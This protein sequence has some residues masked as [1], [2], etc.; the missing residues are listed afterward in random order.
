VLAPRALVDGSF[1]FFLEDTQMKTA[2]RL[3]AIIGAFAA[4]IATSIAQLQGQAQYDLLIRMVALLTARAHP[5]IAPTWRFAMA[6]LPRLAVWPRQEPARLM[7][8]DWSSRPA[9]LI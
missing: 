3:L 7:P 5:G 6:A 9:S 4:F 1:G 8:P 2:V